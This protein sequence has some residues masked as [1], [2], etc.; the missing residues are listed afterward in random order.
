MET[1]RQTVGHLLLLSV[2]SVVLVVLA[3]CGAGAS[4]NRTKE[5]KPVEVREYEG[6]KLSSVDDF[7]ENSIKGPQYVDIDTYRLK[8]TGLVEN[9]K[10]YT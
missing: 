10:S 1:R 5:L 8:V 2:L 7:R 3:G 9:P 6:A 4:V